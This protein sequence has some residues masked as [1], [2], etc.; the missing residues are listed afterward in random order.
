MAGLQERHPFS[1]PLYG[2]SCLAC[3]SLAGIS[4]SGMKAGL[5]DRTWAHPIMAGRFWMPHPKKRVKVGIVG[6]TQ[7]PLAA[8]CSCYFSCPG[9]FQ[10]GPASVTAIREGD[11]HL[12]HDGPF[13]FAEVNADYITWLW[14]EDQRRE[15]VYSDTKKI[16]R[17]ISTKAVGSDS[18]VDIT[19][20][21]KYPEGKGY[22]VVFISLPT[23]VC[24]LHKAHGKSGARSSPNVRMATVAPGSLSIVYAAGICLLCLLHT[25]SGLAFPYTVTIVLFPQ[26]FAICQGLYRY[27]NGIIIVQRVIMGTV[28]GGSNSTSREHGLGTVQNNRSCHWNLS[29][30]RLLP[31]P[32]S[33]PG[34]WKNLHLLGYKNKSLFFPQ[35]SGSLDGVVI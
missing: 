8:H 20:L 34:L 35:G 10:C 28:A 23:I 31:Q 13:V 27:A 21:Y 19:G 1:G 24:G 26:V 14:H 7:T 33:L 32:Y 16:G 29:L 12:A 9:M 2:H 30:P 11:V 5:H 15:R 22:G 17:C 25:S 4:M 3:V 18:R 6:W